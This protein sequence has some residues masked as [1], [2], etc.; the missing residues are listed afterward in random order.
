MGFDLKGV[1]RIFSEIRFPTSIAHEAQGLDTGHK[2]CA[3]KSFISL[4]RSPFNHKQ[5]HKPYLRYSKSDFISI[6]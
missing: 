6:I 1:L 3:I 2:L 4:F 5:E